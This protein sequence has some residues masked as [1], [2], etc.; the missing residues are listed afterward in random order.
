MTR[1]TFKARAL[2]IVRTAAP[3]DLAIHSLAGGCLL[4]RLF[5][6]RK[7]ALE[8][9]RAWE[10]I[11]LAFRNLFGVEA[12]LLIGLNDNFRRSVADPNKARQELLTYIKSLP[13]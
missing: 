11:H 2:K 9:E 8:T 3:E 7:V 12:S 13:N 5:E 4:E 10:R 6:Y 1:K